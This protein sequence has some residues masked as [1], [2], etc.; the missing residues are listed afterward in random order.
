VLAVDD[1]HV[2]KVCRLGIR[3]ADEALSEPCLPCAPPERF[4]REAAAMSNGAEGCLPLISSVFVQDWPWNGTSREVVGLLYMPRLDGTLFSLLKEDSVSDKE[5]LGWLKKILRAV[6][7]FFECTG[8]IHGDP[9]V[10]NVGY[11]GEEII[12]FFLIDFGN[13]REASLKSRVDINEHRMCWLTTILDSCGIVNE[14][15]CSWFF[16]E[17]SEFIF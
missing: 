1:D 7:N 3:S 11:K 6:S 5:L 13:V 2:I 17:L 15:R 9:S 10:K 8:L 12:E 4:V 16:D 14:K